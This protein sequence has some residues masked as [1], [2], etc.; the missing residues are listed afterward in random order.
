MNLADQLDLE[1]SLGRLRAM[2]C[3]LQALVLTHP[4]PEA[5]SDALKS[6]ARAAAASPDRNGGPHFVEASD[7]F[8]DACEAFGRAAEVAISTGAAHASLRPA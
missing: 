2:E 1:N 6:L 8:R 3:A 7:G 4:N 5:F